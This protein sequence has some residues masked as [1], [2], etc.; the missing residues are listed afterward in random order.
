MSK[1]YVLRNKNF[2]SLKG[3]FLRVLDKSNFAEKGERIV[4]KPNI[5]SPFPSSTGATTD[6]RIVEV[7]AKYL[8]RIGA[9]PLIIEAPIQIYD[10]EETMKITGF[11]RMCK[12]LRIELINSEE[13]KW[14][15]ISLDREDIYLPKTLFDADGIINIPKLKTHT[16]TGVSLG[17]KNLMGFLNRKGR[18]KFHSK[19]IDMLIAL[20]NE[21]LL[22]R[23]RLSVVEGIMGMEGSGPTHGKPVRGD[24]LIVG[25]NNIS[26]DM[27]ACKVMGVDFHSVKQINYA[28]ERNLPGSNFEK[29]K[30][31]GEIP[32]LE[33]EIPLRKKSF[34]DNW[35]MRSRI[36]SWPLKKL[37]IP[38]KIREKPVIL[39]ERCSRCLECVKM[40]AANAITPPKIDY[41]K[42]VGC[43]QCLEVCPNLAIKIEGR[44]HK[45]L[46]MLFG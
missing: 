27:V 23:I 46:R 8:K 6:V 34:L 25:D 26:V 32:A 20:L 19:N 35:A 2:I 4:L 33:F 39:E 21:K 14:V 30:I 18:R 38:L 15:R 1:V 12:D 41:K 16:L 40:C 31:S 13:D 44:K 11:K 45:L 9:E 22:H 5:S 17:M 3:E 42:C 36:I 7:I 43:M 10:F 24:L 37:N 29:I 28:T